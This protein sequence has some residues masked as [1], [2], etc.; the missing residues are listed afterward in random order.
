MRVLQ[1]AGMGVIAALLLVTTMAG[2]S[3]ASENLGVAETAAQHWFV[4]PQLGYAVL[5]LLAAA[6]LL[7]RRPW[8]TWPLRGWAVCVTVTASLAP[9]PWGGAGIGPSLTAGISALV[10]AVLIV[11]AAERLLSA[12][13]PRAPGTST[14]AT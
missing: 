7:L 1:Y 12:G 3:D 5:G 8:T 2:V 13:R 6:G 4:L 10:L 14:D 9:A 11:L